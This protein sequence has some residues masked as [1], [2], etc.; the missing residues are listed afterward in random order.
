MDTG[1]PIHIQPFIED[2]GGHVSTMHPYQNQPSADIHLSARL[3]DTLQETKV[4]LA[5]I[6]KKLQMHKECRAGYCERQKK[7][8]EE[9][10]CCFVFPKECREASGFDCAAGRE[11]L[12]MCYFI[13]KDAFFFHC[14]KRYLW[15]GSVPHSI[16]L[17]I[18]Q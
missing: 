14:R 7:S 5:E 11:S 17:Q 6:I 10:V 15:P 8:T 3:F 4:E 18:G 16:R 1:N 2:W 9:L 13:S 12:L